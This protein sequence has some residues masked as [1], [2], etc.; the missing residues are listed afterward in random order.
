MGGYER[1]WKN[2]CVREREKNKG[3]NRGFFL[4]N[5]VK[6]RRCLMREEHEKY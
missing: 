5:E 6:E 4:V 2:G 3:E 1:G